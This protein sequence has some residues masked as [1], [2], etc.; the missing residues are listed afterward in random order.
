[1]IG[2]SMPP[3]DFYLRSLL[4][5]GLDTPER[6]TIEVWDISSRQKME[7]RLLTMF[8]KSNVSRIRFE[9]TGFLGFVKDK[10][11]PHSLGGN[12]TRLS[13]EGEAKPEKERGES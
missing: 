11:N 5:E 9:S 7:E 4:A 12:L 6:P 13:G 2:Y 3:T 10:V 8:G 1:V